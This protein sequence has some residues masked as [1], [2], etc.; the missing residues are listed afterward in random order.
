MLHIYRAGGPSMAPCQQRIEYRVAYTVW[1]CQL[2][3]APTY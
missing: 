2:G 3:L 1:R